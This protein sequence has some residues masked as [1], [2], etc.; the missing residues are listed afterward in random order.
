MVRELKAVNLLELDTQEQVYV[1]T[2]RATAGRPLIVLS[3]DALAGPTN[4]LLSAIARPG[5][6]SSEGNAL[7]G[8]P[9]G[10]VA[11]FDVEVLG[12]V[13]EEFETLPDLEPLL[14]GKRLEVTL[15]GGL[16][17]P[18]GSRRAPEWHQNRPPEV[19][20]SSP[21]L[22]SQASVLL[23]LRR[24]GEDVELP[25]GTVVGMGSLALSTERLDPDYP[26]EVM[27]HDGNTEASALLR[28][29][30]ANEPRQPSPMAIVQLVADDSGVVTG[31]VRGLGEAS[32][33]VGA[34]IVLE[35][36]LRELGPASLL[37]PPDPNWLAPEPAQLDEQDHAAAKRLTSSVPEDLP[38]CLLAPGAHHWDIPTSMGAETLIGHCRYCGSYQRFRN[39]Y[40]PKWSKAGSA[41]PPTP[42]KEEVERAVTAVS[43][44]VH[45]T[46]P[47]ATEDH[48]DWDLLLDALST[49]G[50]GSWSTFAALCQQTVSRESSKL[51]ARAL[52]SLGH[53]ELDLSQD[54][55]QPLAWSVAP[56]AIAVSD[57]VEPF[58]AGFRSEALVSAI[59][60]TAQDLGGSLIRETRPGQPKVIRILGLDRDGLEIVAV[61]V[62]DVRQVRVVETPASRLLERLPDLPSMSARLP[63]ASW[64]PRFASSFDLSSTQWQAND[65]LVAEGA[66][67]R[68]DRQPYRYAMVDQ[69]LS[70][71][72]LGL[73]LGEV[74]VVKYLAA[75]RQNRPLMA[76][77][78]EQC[79]LTVPLGAELPWLY[80]RVAVLCSGV[81]PTRRGALAIYG[82]VSAA[83]AAGLWARPL[84]QQTVTALSPRRLERSLRE[85]YLRYYN[86]AFWLRDAGLMAERGQLLSSEGVIFTEPR[87]EPV[88]PYESTEVL[89]E[90]CGELALDEQVADALGWML[91]RADGGFKLR[92]HQGEALRCSLAAAAPWNPV[93]TSGTGSG[94]T[95]SFLLPIF[96]RLLDESLRW[97]ADQEE[98]EWWREEHHAEPWRGWRSNEVRPSAVRALIVYP[99]NALVEDQISRVRGALLR[100]RAGLG[101]FRRL[102]FGRYT[103]V[104]PGDREAPVGTT[105]E[106]LRRSGALAADIRKLVEEAEQ[107]AEENPDLANEFQSP[108]LGEM[109]TRWDMVANPPD[110]LVTNFSMLNVMMARTREERLFES[111]ARWLAQDKRNAFTLVVDELH[112]YR[113]TPGTEIALVVRALL[114]RLGLDSDSSQLRCIGTSASLPE[115]TEFLEQFFGVPRES[116]RVIK[117][118]PIEPLPIQLSPDRVRRVATAPPDGSESELKALLTECD[119]A[120][121]VANAC[122]RSVGGELRPSRLDDLAKS[123]FPNCDDRSLLLDVALDA[124]SRRQPMLDAVRFRSHMFMRLVRGMWA[125]SNPDCPEVDNVFRSSTRRVGRLFANPTTTCS[126]GG[127]VLELL[128]CYQCGEPSL[129]GF[130][131]PEGRASDNRGYYLGPSSADLSAATEKPVF[132]RTYSEYAWYWPNLPKQALKT[133]THAG[134]SFSFT[135]AKYHPRLGMLELAVEPDG[136]T[137]TALLVPPNPDDEGRWDIP[138]LPEQCPACLSSEST[139]LK[140]IRS[141]FV[142][143]PVR[144]HTAGADQ[145]AQLLT[146][147][148][149]RSLGEN[150][151]ASRTIIFSDSRDG[152]SETRASLSLNHFRD[153][154]R[155]LL[156]EVAAQPVDAPAMLRAAAAGTLDPRSRQKWN[157]T[158]VPTSTSGLC[159]S[160]VSVVRPR[161]RKW[162]A[163]AAFEASGSSGTD[164]PTL[165]ARVEKALVALGENPAGPR[166]SVQTFGPGIPWQLVHD[167]PVPGLWSDNVTAAERANA[168]GRSKRELSGF[169]AGAV[170]DRAGRDIESIGLGFVRPNDESEPLPGLDASTSEEC[171]RS[172]IRVMGLAE[173]YEGSEKNG[174]TGIPAAVAN[175]VR[176]VAKV[177]NTD[178]GELL[179]S[180]EL[181]LRE[182]IQ[183]TD[184]WKL[185][186]LSASRVFSIVR[187]TTKS[188]YRC[189]SCS[190][191]HLHRSAGVCTNPACLSAE[192]IEVDVGED[193][194]DYYAWLADH[195]PRRLR[196]RELTGQTKPLALR[197]RAPAKV[198]RLPPEASDRKPVNRSDRRT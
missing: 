6:R 98:Y 19:V 104:T 27:V 108:S 72:G 138:A 151:M 91:Y 20:V 15:L 132:R 196:V 156:R 90:V 195:A 143:S 32:L 107:V 171:I 172:A 111:T 128:Y 99:T 60:T 79:A 110:I 136:A 131:S 29:R 188:G 87:L 8:V 57:H 103:G 14:P 5:F 112:S 193:G 189:T 70:G 86:T 71:G 163:L 152:A 166:E 64:S 33:V 44:A 84:E 13:P 76:Y 11:F 24:L 127:V 48:A 2:A 10:W 155:Q 81:Q 181:V 142:R 25:V 97:P 137:G 73:I 96:A 67:L 197:A 144:G 55:S 123:L 56:A 17:L 83:L 61:K 187:A 185:P 26:W 23:R 65:G 121:A 59:E 69:A 45:A 139:T 169:V 75:L 39:R 95:E 53:V 122:D 133:W 12:Q 94:K 191:V 21:H 89:R 47:V 124:V 37:P 58:L 74:R 118:S 101:P 22:D 135:R 80:D 9:E 106:S 158:S 141:G 4:E 170:F 30:S 41:K 168:L 150:P 165:I 173:L 126:C 38:A 180:V 159:T 186:V 164:W 120:S 140:K 183:V 162:R 62:R 153:L 179:A 130:I 100:L 93:V 190:R 145:V 31:S 178:P 147:T 160:S 50:C 40:K 182:K 102:Y 88:L 175:Y 18:G 78:K 49:V 66:A 92:P 176:A 34:G 177:N 119:V 36:L 52:S 105:K 46:S 35:P 194:A 114:R 161:L 68:S 43:T 125:C 85:A 115:G 146:S 192:F 117:G 77:D 54:R 28:L 167:P 109:L 1:E 51:I 148:L 198:Q 174:L 116:F 113:G 134:Q 184:D 63:R 82:N 16:A 42:R 3:S 157:N 7:R 149:V 154:V 129:G